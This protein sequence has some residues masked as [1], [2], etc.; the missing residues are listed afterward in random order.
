[1]KDA[2]TKITVTTGVVAGAN[3]M[4]EEVRA[5]SSNLGVVGL[6]LLG[7]AFGLGILWMAWGYW[8]EKRGEKLEIEGEIG[9]TQGMY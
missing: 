3:A 1:M 4:S 7:V 8:R 6:T 9:A 2:G 5:L